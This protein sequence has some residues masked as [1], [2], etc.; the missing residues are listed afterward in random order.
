VFDNPAG[1]IYGTITVAAI[2][3]AESARQETYPKTLAAM[4][5][6][7]ILYWLAHSYSYYTGD[8]LEEGDRFTYAGLARTSV[9]ELS[10]LLGGAIPFLVMLICWA[11]GV[12][13]STAVTVDVLTAA[14]IVVA[15]E[16][17]IGI[18]GKLT[19]R[20]LIRQTVV[21]ATLG[22]LIVALRVLLH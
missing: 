6:A 13:L 1:L 14:G 21:G 19:G 17:V 3:A 12:P 5:V 10:V 7:L 15:I 4:A 2:V 8:R 11:F 16:V 18:R 22:V 9:R 20:E